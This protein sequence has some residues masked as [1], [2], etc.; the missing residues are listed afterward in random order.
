MTHHHHHRQGIKSGQVSLC[1]ES[2]GESRLVY[3]AGW[4]HKTMSAFHWH[5]CW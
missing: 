3:V 2:S 1:I 4:T 5:S